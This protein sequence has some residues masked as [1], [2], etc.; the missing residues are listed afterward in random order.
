MA[1]RNNDFLIQIESI[2]LIKPI[3][4][5]ETIS[6]TLHKIVRNKMIST[7][8]V[9]YG[10]GLFQDQCMSWLIF[11]QCFDNNDLF[12]NHWTRLDRRNDLITSRIMGR[13]RLENNPSSYQGEF[14]PITWINSVS[15]HFIHSETRSSK[16]DVFLLVG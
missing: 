4:K 12:D 16:M 7:K 5:L 6:V 11:F 1:H 15:F 3:D 14:R 13:T 9:F 10:I 2:C 8:L